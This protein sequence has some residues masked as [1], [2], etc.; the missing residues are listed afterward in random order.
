MRQGEA[1]TDCFVAV[2]G[3]SVIKVIDYLPGQSPGNHSVD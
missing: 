1:Q 3:E 2:S